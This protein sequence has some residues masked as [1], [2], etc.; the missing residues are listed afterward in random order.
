MFGLTRRTLIILGLL[1]VVV[2]IVITH[3]GDDKT[4]TGST[5]GCQVQV[6]ADVLNVHSGPHVTD[7]VV[8]KLHTG[9]IKSA[10]PTVQGGFRELTDN[11]WASDQF[12]KPVS[13]SC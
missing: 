4:A 2:V 3:K 12:L 5:S 13:G 9:A 8:A 1:L 6:N 7:K 11:Q 10:T